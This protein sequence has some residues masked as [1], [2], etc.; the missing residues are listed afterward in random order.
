MTKL[1]PKS[2]WKPRRVHAMP[3]DEQKALYICERLATSSHGL[4]RICSEEGLPKVT[5][6]FKWLRL[7]PDFAQLYALAREAQGQFLADETLDIADETKED[8]VKRLNYQGGLEGWEVNGEAISRSKLRI[9]T[10]KW[11][12]AHLAPH[13][14][15]ERLDVSQKISA[16][17]PLLAMLG[18]IADTG[19][20]IV[21]G[22]DVPKDEGEPEF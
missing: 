20:R 8:Y 1:K 21:P 3:Y 18:R 11:H 22:M 14:Y 12:A 13:K 9:D 5:T 19:R 17:D 4:A 6:V 2:E 10:R 15:G 7:N 16:D